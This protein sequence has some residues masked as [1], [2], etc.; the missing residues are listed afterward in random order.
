MVDLC[1]IASPGAQLWFPAKFSEVF[2]DY[3][4]DIAPSIDISADFLN[5]VSVQI[6]PSGAGEMT[7]NNL[8]P[9]TDKITITLSGG[10]PSRV[11]TIRYVVSMSDNRTYTFIAYIMIPVELPGFMVAPP[12]D[13]GF[14]DPLTWSYTPSLNFTEP[15][16]SM[17]LSLI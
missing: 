8:V 14:G 9:L 6:A 15:R 4:L 11:Y 1:C 7:A 5:S 3:T 2:L 10:V 13:P 17:Y 12:P 16:N